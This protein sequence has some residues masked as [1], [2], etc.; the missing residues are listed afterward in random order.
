MVNA[1]NIKFIILMGFFRKRERAPENT[2]EGWG[3]VEEQ[4]ERERENLKQDPYSAQSP[5]WGLIS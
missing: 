2:C 3:T 4:R 1:S 5:I